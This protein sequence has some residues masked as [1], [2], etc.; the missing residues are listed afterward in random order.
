MIKYS[1]IYITVQIILATRYKVFW[2]E[3]GVGGR[4]FIWLIIAGEGVKQRTDHRT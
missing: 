1:N 3:G 2:G 4:L